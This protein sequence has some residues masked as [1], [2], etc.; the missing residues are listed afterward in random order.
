MEKMKPKT[1][2]LHREFV[3]LHR[4]KL[5]ICNL[6]CTLCLLFLLHGCSPSIPKIQAKGELIGQ[7]INTTVDSE[8]AKYYLENY[9]S[10]N[11]TNPK[12]DKRIELV[13]QQ[14]NGQLPDRCALKAISDSFSVDFA[15]LFFATG[16]WET[17]ANRKAQNIFRKKV[18]ERKTAIQNHEHQS[19][20][21]AADYIILFVPGW[22]YKKSG[23]K[24]GSDLATPRNLLAELGLKNH[25]VEIPPNGSVEENAKFLTQEILRFSKLEKSIILVGASSAGP[26]I[27]LTLGGQLNPQQLQSVKAWINLGGILQGSPLIEYLQEWPRNWLLEIGLRAKRWEKKNVLS[28]SV[29]RSRKRFQRLKLPDHI[30]VINYLGLSL[31]GELSKYSLDKYPIL[32][33]EGPND[34]LT[35]LADILAPGSITIIAPGSDHFFNEDPEIDIKT[36]ALAQTAIQY[37]KTE[38]E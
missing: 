5:L 21:K 16:I 37:L 23:H 38:G 29:N 24:T 32:R 4:T 20:S 14:H 6:T 26:A 36:V 1:L 2:Q 11:R 10:N 19:V 30:L 9:L 31:S 28:M 8:I 13:Y 12:F 25:L 17:E 22:D 35:L 18:A 7:P 27:H 34:G 15:A 33:R 3:E